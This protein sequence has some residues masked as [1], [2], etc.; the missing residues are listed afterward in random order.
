MKWGVGKD[1]LTFVR[2][3]PYGC[4]YFYVW[5][6]SLDVASGSRFRTFNK[7]VKLCILGVVLFSFISFYLSLSSLNLRLY[8]HAIIRIG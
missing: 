8:T 3:H 5:C 1:L 2:T 4:V 6:I 7:K